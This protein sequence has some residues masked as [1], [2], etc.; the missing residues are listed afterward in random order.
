M[1]YL[2]IPVALLVVC[3]GCSDT[4]DKTTQQKNKQNHIWKGQTET[5]ERTKGLET[6]IMDA[7]KSRQDNIQ[8]HTR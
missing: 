6:V 8:Q 2:V 1:R 3:A 4:T 5:M 7:A